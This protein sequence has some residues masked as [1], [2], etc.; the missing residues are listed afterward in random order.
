MKLKSG[1]YDYSPVISEQED[2]MYTFDEYLN[3]ENYEQSD[4]SPLLSKQ[5][6]YESIINPVEEENEEEEEK[7][8]S[9]SKIPKK[10]VSSTRI[11]C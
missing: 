3:A 5:Q 8:E 1:F 2:I 4:E 10:S 11:C 9:A 6:T 7:G